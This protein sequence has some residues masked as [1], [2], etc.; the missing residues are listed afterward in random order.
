MLKK[1][2]GSGRKLRDLPPTQRLD[3][4]VSYGY[5]D[6]SLV[7]GISTKTF[8]ELTRLVDKYAEN[9]IGAFPMAW[10]VAEHF[11]VNGRMI[12][13]VPMVT[14][15]PTV[16]AAASK[17]AKMVNEN[18]FLVSDIRSNE[19]GEVYFSRVPN[20]AEIF[21]R[22]QADQEKL[23]DWLRDAYD[24]MKKHGGGLLSVKAYPSLNG[25]SG[26]TGIILKINAAVADAMG[27]NVTT[28]MAELLGEHVGKHYVDKKPLMAI[29]SN[30]SMSRVIARAVWSRSAVPEEIAERIIDAQEFAEI[31]VERAVTHNKGIM[32]GIVAVGQV[33]GQDT[34]ALN[35]AAHAFA[36]H[37][38]KGYDPLT[39]YRWTDEGLYGKLTVPLPV[40]V[41][42]GATQNAFAELS[43]DLM[44]T[45]TSSQLK[46]VMASVGL[47]QNFAALYALVTE[48]IDTAKKRI[49]K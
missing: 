24:P 48:G 47:A 28:R 4:L 1:L 11:K 17:A 12:N 41:V 29:C 7:S 37:G 23:A 32:N 35:A 36:A 34:R 45:R 3:A 19:I 22:L 2:R 5:L 27:A 43:R 16:I 31:R 30:K 49:I 20:A 18:G 14:E 21:R 40:G 15:E 6:R 8:R 25:K 42:G 38:K 26:K 44:W 33:T 46:A 39:K 10:G 9:V 13:G